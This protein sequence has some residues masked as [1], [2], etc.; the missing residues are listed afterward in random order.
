MKPPKRTPEAETE[1]HAREL[2]AQEFEHS[3]MPVAAI[4]AR[5]GYFPLIVRAIKRGMRAAGR[6]DR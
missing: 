5:Q 4:H 3:R 2:L 1:K 6:R